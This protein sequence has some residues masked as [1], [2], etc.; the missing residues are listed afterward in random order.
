MRSLLALITV[1]GPKGVNPFACS[2]VWTE[3]FEDN[4]PE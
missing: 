1:L 3:V 2:E 4:A